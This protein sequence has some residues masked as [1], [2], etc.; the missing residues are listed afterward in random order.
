M[1][2][3]IRMGLFLVFATGI[4]YVS[5][6]FSTNLKAELSFEDRVNAQRSMEKIFYNHR[7]WPEENGPRKSFHEAMS[8]EVLVR[9]TENYVKK[10]ILLDKHWKSPLTGEQL[11]AEM[12]RIVERTRDPETLSELFASLHN[13][14]RLIA[15]C[16]VRPILVNRLIRNWY[17]RDQRIHREL[18]NR[19]TKLKELLTPENMAHSKEGIYREIHIKKSD[20]RELNKPGSIDDKAAMTRTNDDYL[21]SDHFRKVISSFPKEPGVIRLAETNDAFIF[22]TTHYVSDQE[23]KAATLRLMKKSFDQ[24][25]QEIQGDVSPKDI[26]ADAGFSY[27][28][29]NP[30][31]LNGNFQPDEWFQETFVPTARI[32][33]SAVWTGSEMIIWGGLSGDNFEENNLNTGAKYNPILD[34]WIPTTTINAPLGRNDHPALWTG[35]K[36]IIWG[37][38]W[39]LDQPTYHNTGGMYDPVL[40]EWTTITTTNAPTGRTFHA[41]VWTGL[42]M[43]VWGG[44][45]ADSIDE[46]TGGRFNPGTN[47][48][49]ELPDY[50]TY[51]NTSNV[52]IPDTNTYVSSTIQVNH[53][54]G[55]ITDIGVE[56]NILHYNDED[57]DIR[58]RSPEGTYIY[59]STD[60]GG[61]PVKSSIIFGSI[62]NHF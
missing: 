61:P 51:E 17:A 2:K 41:A 45:S 59:L 24:W 43:I 34:T 42:E 7:L 53:D 10:S 46:Y 39:G 49:E 27:Q 5:Q 56:L 25:F 18:K 38:D 12:D 55:D 35:T 21:D 50:V 22:K 11:Q 37:G 23:L 3:L 1:K 29:R 26:E 20:L 6:G 30:K 47:T 62:C 57:L 33:H 19:A 13:D 60:N 31:N 54:W 48:W 28:F 4:F 14:P 16:L 58:L 52:Y 9:K 36:M 40:D 32:Y 44:L 15:E 8:E